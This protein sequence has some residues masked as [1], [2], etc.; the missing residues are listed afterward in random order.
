MG[1]AHVGATLQTGDFLDFDPLPKFS[2]ASGSMQKN[3]EA[4][5][6]LKNP[7]VYCNGLLPT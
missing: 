1:F 6:K 7:F 5:E 2:V 4:I 3:L